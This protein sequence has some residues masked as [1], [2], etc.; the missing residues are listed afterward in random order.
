MY[1]D[2]DFGIH[3][4]VDLYLLTE[5][6]SL[7]RIS[8]ESTDY[9]LFTWEVEI[10]L[11]ISSGKIEFFYS[12]CECISWSIHIHV[13]FSKSFYWRAIK[14]LNSEWLN[15]WFNE[16]YKILI[17]KELNFWKLLVYLYKYILGL[18]IKMFQN[19]KWIFLKIFL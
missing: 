1:C 4:R 6:D 11:M 5:I 2:N 17:A 19:Q 12:I 13:Y 10:S 16:N 3:V 9:L 8:T 14:F 15:Y 18:F 7:I